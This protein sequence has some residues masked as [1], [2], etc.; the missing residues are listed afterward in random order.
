MP[1]KYLRVKV[2][3]KSQKNEIVEK[4][5][6]GTLKIRI[7]AVPERGKANAELIKFLSKELR[8]P[9]TNIAIISG[10]ADQLKLIRI[11]GSNK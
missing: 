5:E 9:K 3:P 6:D 10:A 11:Y 2:I 7:K 4:L 8:I 1:E